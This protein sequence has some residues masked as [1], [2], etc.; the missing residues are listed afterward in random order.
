MVVKLYDSTAHCSSPE[1]VFFRGP[2]L[3]VHLDRSS[4]VNVRSSADAGK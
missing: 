4:L 1:Y 2:R 3:H